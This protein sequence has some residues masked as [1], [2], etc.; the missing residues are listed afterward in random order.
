MQQLVKK[1][2]WESHQSMLKNAI[3][4]EGQGNQLERVTLLMPLT[5]M[6][7][8]G[9]AVKSFVVNHN[10]ALSNIL[11]VCDDL[12][13]PFGQI[14]LRSKGRDGG[15]NGLASIEDALQSSAYA[16]LRM[17]IG[18][19]DSRVDPA[20]YVLARFS[21]QEAQGVDKF[22][23]RAVECCL[24][25]LHAGIEKSMEQFNQPSSET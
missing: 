14:R 20:A 4:V 5:Y 17:G 6:N 25:W 1:Q 10:I 7:K 11:V 13:L 2:K 15:H 9:Q 21:R 23:H 24:F 16:R 19:P 18:R 12:N 8:S 22:V 3:V